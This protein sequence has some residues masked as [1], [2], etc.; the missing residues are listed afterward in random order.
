MIH[1]S[2][3]SLLVRRL[4]ALR[5]TAAEDLERVASLRGIRSRR[6]ELDVL[7]EDFERQIDRV[8][9]AAVI[10]LVGSTGAGKSSLL[11]ALV[12]RDLATPGVNRP[13][14]RRPTVFCPRDADI[15]ELLSG[16]PGE[17]PFVEYY[18]PSDDSP[19]TEQV[20]IDAPDVNGPVPE[21]RAVVAA[22]AERSDVLLCVFHDQ[23]VME[24]AAVSFLS[25]YARRRHLV[26]LLNRADELS[27]VARTQLLEQLDENA[28]TLWHLDQP[29]VLA[30]SAKQA[31]ET[32]TAPGWDELGRVLGEL[33]MGNAG[34]DV[35]GAV[36]RRNAVGT[37]RSLEE[38][39]RSAREEDRRE[40]EQLDGEV[41]AGVD[42]LAAF[43]ADEVAARLR[44]RRSEFAQLLWGEV[45]KRWD[46]PCGWALRSGNLGTL[47]LGAGA[48]LARR[49]P[50]L[51][52]GAAVGGIA[53]GKVREAVQKTQLSE[54]TDLLPSRGAFEAEYAQAMT[55]ARGAARVLTGTPEGLPVPAPED[56]WDATAAA[57][58]DEWN[59]V[60][61][62]DLP[63]LAESSAHPWV[64]F[65]ADLPVYALGAFVVWKAGRGFFAEPAQYVGVDFLVNVSLLL[66]AYLFL[67]RTLIRRYLGFRADRLLGRVIESVRGALGGLGSEASGRVRAATDAM[68]EA[69]ERLEKL[70]EQLP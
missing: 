2:S 12:G 55:A 18:D 52:A 26:L 24:D 23:S 65:G 41:A 37:A 47:G 70:D 45:G 63:D 10:T 36:R 29:T 34:G 6:L 33:V 40:L 46:G 35:L 27:D 25:E 51:A 8:R 67:V 61:G 9:R 7:L 68:T 60:F 11:N 19:W 31:R 39:V 44:L 48:L 64:R 42:R 50:L 20:L 3:Q 38:L 43:T 53:A 1:R 66:L 49:N 54:P 4:E 32:G 14:T 22:L 30:T 59:D 56:A 17:P 16:L 13:T 57:V 62:R 28:R 21:H 58:A 15:D 69:L 5:A